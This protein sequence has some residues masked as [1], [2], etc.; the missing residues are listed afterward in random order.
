MATMFC[1][2]KKLFLYFS[3]CNLLLVNG[4]QY[5]C[6]ALNRWLGKTLALA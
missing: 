5:F 2:Q 1:Y 6:T 4:F 3:T